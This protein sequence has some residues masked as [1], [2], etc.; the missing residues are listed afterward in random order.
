MENTIISGKTS[1]AIEQALPRLLQNHKPTNTHGSLRERKRQALR[2]YLSDTATEMFLLHGFDNVRITE[3]AAA[4]NVSEKTVYNHFPVKESLLLDREDAMAE[5]MRIALGAQDVSPV[6]AMVSMLDDEVR[7]LIDRSENKNNWTDKVA[8]L[9][10]FID[11][12]ETTPSLLSYQQGIMDRLTTVAAKVLA[13]R[14]KLNIDTP[15]PWI[16]ADAIIGLWKVQY[17]ALRRSTNVLHK[18]QEIANMV[19]NDVHRAAQV[20]EGGI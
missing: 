18:P 19:C 13:E 11:I 10:R 4:C 8:M 9:N 3:I 7:A 6:R 20:L 2:Q 14:D 12:I 1:L 5:A 15:E 17:R 16:V